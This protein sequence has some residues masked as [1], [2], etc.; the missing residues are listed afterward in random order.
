MTSV[1]GTD[2]AGYGPNL[3]PLV[4]GAS[5]W[6]VDAP[7]DE[8]VA[9]LDTTLKEAIT[10]GS[11]GAARNRP[12]WADSK[13]L[14]RGGAGLAALELGALAAVSLA[15]GK[16]PT[17]WSGLIAALAV[18]ERGTAPE[19]AARHDLRLPVVAE[20]DEVRRRADVVAE[21]LAR[22]GVRLNTIRCRVV[23]P[24]E[25]NRLLDG[26][27]TKADI[28]T[29]V[30][31]DLAAGLLGG[32]VPA[33]VCCDRHGGR[34]RYAAAVARHF[35][36]PLVQVLE[37]TRDES[38]YLLPERSCRIGFRVGGESQIPVAVASVL[39]KYLRELAMRGFNEFWARR[40]PDTAAT[41]GYPVDAR[42]WRRE[43]AD[44]VAR[45]GVRWDAIWRKA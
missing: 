26:R 21:V 30:T 27:R 37:E 16:M 42:R 19:A 29:Q 31:L 2:E 22:R 32:S 18:D 45:S 7:P 5:S 24:E 28:L 17:D 34:T 23:E 35:A 15:D 20:L 36:T 14:H 9:V 3:G 25:F 43:A 41:A 6:E 1:V 4:V 13:M 11:D 10:A 33:V 39:A 12:L 38:A 44:A 40:S 8:A